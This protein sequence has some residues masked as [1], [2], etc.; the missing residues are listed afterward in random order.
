MLVKNINDT[1]LKKQNFS[2]KSRRGGSFV[3]VPKWF[4]PACGSYRKRSNSTSIGPETSV[5]H[6]KPIGSDLELVEF[7]VAELGRE[8]Y[9]RIT[10]DSPRFFFWKSPKN[11]SFYNT[12]SRAV[13]LNS[14]T[15]IPGRIM[16]EK[17]LSNHFKFTNPNISDSS[18]SEP[19]YT[20]KD[21]AESLQ[22]EPHPQTFGFNMVT[23]Q[24]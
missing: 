12:S 10:S 7:L 1:I 20:G 19:N 15:R 22:I 23:I 16:P 18:N 2:A 3:P 24:R 8:R 6:E 9:N 21:L 5:F 13:S 4:N 11:A 14:D 17:I